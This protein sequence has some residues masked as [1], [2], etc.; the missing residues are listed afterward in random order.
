MA[1]TTGPTHKLSNVK[2]NEISFVGAGDNPQAHVLLLKR[3]PNV[4]DED[5]DI[6]KTKEAQ[7]MP[8]K[9]VKELEEKVSDLE[10]EKADLQAEIVTLKTAP[11]EGESCPT[12]GVTKEAPKD[13]I[14]KSALPEAVRKKLDEQEAEIEKNR[15]DVELLKDAELTREYIGKAAEIGAVGKVDEVGELLKSIGKVSK[16]LAGKVFDVL[17]AA[18]SR[19][20]TGGLFKEMGTDAG[21]NT[22]A[23]AA[24]QIAQKADELRKTCPEL[25]KE[26]AW[27]KVYDTDADLRKQYIAERNKR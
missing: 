1:R 4:K 27:T 9:V 25:T 5:D 26:K 20:K 16:E 19:I 18:D 7:N 14:D 22:G 15:K 23:T 3:K 21:G 12:C 17:K 10:K 24:E 11:K 2:L 13:A 8:E 6:T